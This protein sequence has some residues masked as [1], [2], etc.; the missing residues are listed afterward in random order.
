MW[1][2]LSKPVRKSGRQLYGNFVSRKGTSD[3]VTSKKIL[4]KLSVYH[5]AE[6]KKK[7]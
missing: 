6:N 7:K 2:I 3:A 5:V 4:D 1:D